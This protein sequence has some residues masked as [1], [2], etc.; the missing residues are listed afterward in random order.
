MQSQNAGRNE[1]RT[2]RDHLSHIVNA[3]GGCFVPG[4]T[5]NGFSGSDLG[6]IAIWTVVGLFVAVRR[7]RWEP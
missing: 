6:V 3:F 4:S 7:F 5:G 1:T 2:L